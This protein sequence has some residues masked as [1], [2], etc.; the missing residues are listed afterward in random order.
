[1]TNHAGGHYLL[2]IHFKTFLLGK[3]GPT[4]PV[5]RMTAAFGGEPDRVALRDVGQ[6]FTL[7]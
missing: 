4:E 6:T 7:G 5:E 2:P 3:E 1:M